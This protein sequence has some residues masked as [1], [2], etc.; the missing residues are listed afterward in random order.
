MLKSA[1]VTIEEVVGVF[2]LARDA[3]NKEGQQWQQREAVAARRC[4]GRGV[5]ESGYDSEN[6]SDKGGGSGV[7]RSWQ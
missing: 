1:L 6:N 2:L 3:D 7:I 5:V 4:S